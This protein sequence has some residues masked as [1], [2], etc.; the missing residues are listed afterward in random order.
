MLLLCCYNLYINNYNV[1]FNID[2]KI[3]INYITQNNT[4]I[5]K[6]SNQVKTKN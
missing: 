5:L 2:L 6:T 3:Y 4:I 1:V